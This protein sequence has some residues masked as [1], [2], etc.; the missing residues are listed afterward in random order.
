VNSSQA[1]AEAPQPTKAAKK[2]S[3]KAQKTALA[4]I[5]EG[6]KD[7]NAVPLNGNLLAEAKGVDEAK[8]REIVIKG[9]Q[10]D[11]AYIAARL[12]KYTECVIAEDEARQKRIVFADTFRDPEVQGGFW[13]K[14]QSRFF[15][16]CS[17][18]RRTFRRR[19]SSDI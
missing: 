9:V 8:A 3:R 17:L 2:R 12:E 11:A 6:L 15:R 14:H 1:P 18:V 4:K 7:M 13:Q 19:L 16:N 10:A 5:T